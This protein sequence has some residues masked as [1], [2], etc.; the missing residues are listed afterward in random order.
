MGSGY[1]VAIDKIRS[2]GL[3]AGRVA[4]GLRGA[5]CAESVPTGDL[6]MQG[7]RAALR[8]AEV[9][10]VLVRRLVSKGSG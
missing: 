3:A 8:M 7:S 4:E 10:H 5:G 2:T 9:K 6:G 1:Q